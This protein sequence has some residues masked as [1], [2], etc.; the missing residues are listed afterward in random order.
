MTT[1]LG[2]DPGIGGAL[3]LFD[4]VTDNLFVYDVPTFSLP[5]GKTKKRR[6]DLMG[7]AR[8]ADIVMGSAGEGAPAPIVVI[9]QVNAMPGRGREEG[10]AP[11]TMGATSAF[12]FGRTT[13]N[14]EAVF[15][16]H[17]LR[18]EYVP[19]AKWKRDLKVPAAKDGARARASQ[20]LPAH[21][22]HWTRVKDADRAEAALIAVWA[23]MY[24]GDR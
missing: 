13:G 16:A 24:L 9:E 22:H 20:L 17:F 3:A 11:R 23:S 15:A 7:L 4:D 12:N 6:V 21:A 2:I 18:I 5:S 19:P 10:D 14:L 8:V 1:Y